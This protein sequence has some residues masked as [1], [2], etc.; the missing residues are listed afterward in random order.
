MNKTVH[1][2]ILWDLVE[3]TEEVSAKQ[4]TPASGG[5]NGIQNTNDD[6]SIQDR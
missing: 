5:G 2:T 6:T 4:L 1:D 3:I